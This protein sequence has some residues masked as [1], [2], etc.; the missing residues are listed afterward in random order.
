L[1]DDDFNVTGDDDKEDELEKLITDLLS[2]Q[3]SEPLILISHDKD[4]NTGSIYGLFV[5]I[6]RNFFF[7]YQIT[8][9]GVAYRPCEF[10]RELSKGKLKILSALNTDEMVALLRLLRIS[11]AIG[12]SVT[13]L[14]D[15]DFEDQE[16]ALEIYGFYPPDPDAN[17]AVYYRHEQLGVSIGAQLFWGDDD[18]ESLSFG[19]VN[20]IQTED[21]S[22]FDS[23]DEALDFGIIPKHKMATPFCVFKTLTGFVF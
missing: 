17:P 20:D 18:T 14:D 23:F 21:F 6:N 5:D 1:S 22:V 16:A 13:I 10:I 2:E 4:E 11:K 8:D 12:G 9:S 3:Y 7:D 19:F 15:K